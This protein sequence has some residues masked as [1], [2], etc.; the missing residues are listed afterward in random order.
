M[1]A[2]ENGAKK[3]KR[4][5]QRQ[6]L[7]SLGLGLLF[8]LALFLFLHFRKVPV[9]TLEP[10]SSAKRYVVAE[11]DFF[12]PD[13]SATL[14]IKNEAASSVGMLYRIEEEEIRKEIADFQ[15]KLTQN[16]PLWRQIAKEGFDSLAVALSLLSSE[17]LQSRFADLETIQRIHELSPLELSIQTHPF[18]VFIPGDNYKGRLPPAFWDALGKCFAEEG[19]SLSLISQVL[20]YFKQVSFRFAEDGRTRGS[21]Q[22]LITSKIPVQMTY[23]RSGERIIDQGEEVLG[24][25]VAMLDA[26]RAALSER[27]HLG[28][29]KALA[30]SLVL[31]LLFTIVALLYLRKRHQDIL[32]SGRK[33]ALLVTIA[34]LNIFVA[35]VVEFLLDHERTSWLDPV[36]FALYVPLSSLLVTCLLSF[37]LAI[38]STLFLSTLFVLGLPVES[39]PF[40]VINVLVSIVIALFVREA[41]RRKELFFAALKAWLFALVFIVAFQLYELSPFTFSTVHEIA[42]TLIFLIST[43]ILAL[44]LLPL[45]EYSFQVLTNMTLMEW[46]DPSNALLKRLMLEAPGTYQHS[47]LVGNLAEAAA[48]E[49]G[50][51]ALFCRASALYHDIGKLANPEYFAE[52]SRGVDM[53]QLLTPE[54]SVKVIIGHVKEG[55][56]LAQKAGLPDPFVDIIRQHHGTSLVIYFYHKAMEQAADKHAILEDNYRYSGPKPTSKE[57]TLIMIAD[58]AEAAVRSLENTSEEV[59]SRLLDTIIVH[60]TS[61]HQFD[62]SPLSFA[63]LSKVKA[64][65]LKNLLALRHPRIKYPAHHPGEE[66]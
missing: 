36:R 37:R 12:Y 13:E 35:S 42:S 43:V 53:H 23:L 55:V 41:A 56:L 54:E 27:R 64:V 3:Q 60:R 19:T 9:L 48:S 25:H 52:N 28:D 58:S 6:R 26:M 15:R 39:V 1:T 17:L 24:R 22:R 38:F 33:L 14:F 46:M 32:K 11:V 59:I 45:F 66:G 2:T 44:G 5:R 50:A 34:I 8:V 4:K 65:L 63:E 47:L 16:E 20:T 7:L 40:L 51:N 30:G 29:P 49:I 10:G 61:D 57:S 21:L 62:D 31:S 18:Y